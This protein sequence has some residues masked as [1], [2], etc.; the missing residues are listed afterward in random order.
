MI[1]VI[2]LT[3]HYGNIRAVDNLSF[4]IEQGT[5]FGLLGPNGA[6][7]TTT[8]KILTTLSKPDAGRAVVAEHDVTK[9][10]T[11]VK[12]LMGVVPQENNLDRELTAFENLLI[13]GMLHGVQ[14]REAKIR[15]CLD[16]VELWDR[17]NGMVSRFSGGMQRRLLI[18]RA[19]MTEPTV[20]FLDEPSIGLDP[21]IRRQVWDIIRRTRI[22]GRTV[23]IT[24][25]YIEEAEALCDR[26]AILD[27]GSLIA[28]D[29]PDN[30]KASVGGYIVEFVNAEGK[31]IQEICKDREEANSLVLCTD[32]SVTIRKS[33]L[34]DVFIKLTGERIE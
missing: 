12:R 16:L 3:K 7:K 10:P 23:V 25:H 33:N 17:R 30:L 13:Y 14:D 1:E 26:V 4:R 8:I 24:T 11:S 21:Q 27:K 19:L 2:G 5:V 22:D 32:C 9:D 15:S 18:A 20:L 34:E 31:L 29:T 6:G 28:M